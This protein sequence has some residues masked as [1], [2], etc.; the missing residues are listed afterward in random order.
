MDDYICCLFRKDDPEEAYKTRDFELVKN[1]GSYA[2]DLGNSDDVTKR[3]TVFGQDRR[4]EYKAP[5]YE[6][7]AGDRV[8]CRCKKCRGLILIHYDEFHDIYRRDI[9]WD[10]YV[11]VQSISEADQLCEIHSKYLGLHRLD[12]LDRPQLEYSW[13]ETKPY[14][15]FKWINRSE[16]TE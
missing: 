11:P 5:L 12:D 7:D 8:L 3:V 4:E 10:R 15:V 2:I 16:E 14:E 9:E 13:S 6:F 1:Y